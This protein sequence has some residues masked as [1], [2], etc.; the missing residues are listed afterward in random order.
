MKERPILFN[1]EM[2]QAILA[3]RKTQ[4]RRALRYQPRRSDILPNLCFPRTKSEAENLYPCG[5]IYPNARDE[6]LDMCPFGKVGDCL[7]VRETWSVISHTFSDDGLM[8][9]WT[10]DRPAVAVKEM[11]FGNGYYSGHAIYRADGGMEW[12]DDDGCHTEQSF[13]KPSIH[14][15]RKACRII[16]E[17]TGVRV[18]RLRDIS[19][20]DAVAEGLNKP[21]YAPNESGQLTPP[22][23]E[24]LLSAFP[25]AKHWFST[26]WDG[27]Y[28]NWAENPWVWVIEFR[29]LTT[30]GVVSGVA[31]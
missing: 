27:A 5:Y 10:P 26:V 21:I 3:G 30:N 16:L 22:A 1:T 15:P 23:G 25:T 2:V 14:M 12:S 9:D 18:E 11:P 6:I 17:I 8:V 20:S 28:G 24:T 13:W 4:T 19:E 31:A 7:W 29:I